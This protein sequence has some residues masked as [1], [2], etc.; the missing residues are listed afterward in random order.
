MDNQY[1]VIH[2]GNIIPKYHSTCPKT[3]LILIHKSLKM[4]HHPQ[5]MTK[6][7]SRSGLLPLAT[8]SSSTTSTTTASTTSSG[9]V[10]SSLL[11]P[12]IWVKTTQ[13]RG[14]R[15]HC[16]CG[17]PQKARRVL[18]DGKGI[19]GANKYGNNRI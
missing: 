11:S 8:S 12:C 16:C 15:I 19:C 10:S 18:A 5:N 7:I 3:I 17:V 14:Q 4:I 1:I 9:S 2:A 13:T 6:S